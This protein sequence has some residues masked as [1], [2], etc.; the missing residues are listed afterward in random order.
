MLYSISY[1]VW[2]LSL[3]HVNIAYSIP[4]RGVFSFGK[5]YVSGE[6]KQIVQQ[7]LIPLYH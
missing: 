1:T 3:M 6:V 5:P 2:K 7:D 4:C